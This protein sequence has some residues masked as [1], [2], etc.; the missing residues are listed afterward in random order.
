MTTADLAQ[1]AL[2]MAVQISAAFRS[3]DAHQV[4]AMMRGFEEQHGLPGL[5][6]LA[7]T[8]A[9][10]LVMITPGEFRDAHGVPVLARIG[11]MPG[12]EAVNQRMRANAATMGD[13]RPI[14]L[15]DTKGIMALHAEIE[16]PAQDLVAAAVT[17][18]VTGSHDRSA[19]ILAQLLVNDPTTR[20]LQATIFYLLGSLG[21][22]QLPDTHS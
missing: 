16:T 11:S 13:G 15:A 8:C 3:G 22:L 2:L 17:E 1:Q 19:V 10:M 7:P 18:A 6:V 9:Q 4:P 14:T 5:H 20:Q 21:R 12:E